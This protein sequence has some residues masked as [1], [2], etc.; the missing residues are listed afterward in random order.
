VLEGGGEGLSLPVLG[1]SILSGLASPFSLQSTNRFTLYSLSPF[2][3][4]KSRDWASL[5]GIINFAV[6]L[7]EGIVELGVAAES[8]AQCG[9]NGGCDLPKL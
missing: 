2:N 3:R 9:T 5:S 7:E 4:S 6:L 8:I 1:L